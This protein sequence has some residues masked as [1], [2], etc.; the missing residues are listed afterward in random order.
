MSAN[1]SPEQGYDVVLL[2]DLLHF[3]ASHDVLLS[4]LTSLLKKSPSART[5]VAAGKY[6]PALVCDHFIRE[7]EKLGLVWEEGEDDAEWRGALDVRGGGL[8]REQLGIRKGMCRWWVGR[9]SS[10]TLATCEACEGDRV[11]SICSAPE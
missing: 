1:E 6:T 2:S 10:M 3:D 8:D 4:S 5:Y 11:E 9:W 7:G